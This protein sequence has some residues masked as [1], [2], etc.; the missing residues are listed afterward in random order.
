MMG[1]ELPNQLG[2]ALAD[3]WFA[4]IGR[5]CPGQA[6]APSPGARDSFRDPVGA[7]LRRSIEVLATE[8]AAEFDRRR[9]GSALETI[10]RLRAVQDTSPDISIAMVGLARD[11]ARQAAARTGSSLG[12]DA[13]AVARVD[14]R[15]RELE[16]TALGLF[17]ASRAALRD[18][19]QREA[20]RRRFVP[21]R[22]RARHRQGSGRII[23]P[24]DAA[25][26]GDDTP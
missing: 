16:L 7:T 22:I 10:V 5:M 2:A 9:A 21:D 11:A 17:E 3:E 23:S 13:S 19:S 24:P 12:G 8:I 1:R 6:G 20:M 26:S 18:I 4:R 14:E 15:V 25:P